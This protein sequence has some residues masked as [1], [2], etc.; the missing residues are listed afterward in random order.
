MKVELQQD[1]EDKAQVRERTESKGVPEFLKKK[2]I[3]FLHMCQVSE[4]VLLPPVWKA[5]ADPPKQHQLI[6]L[7]HAF[8]DT[9]RRLSFGIPIVKTYDPLTM[10][11]NQPQG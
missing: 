10:L 4:H 11:L 8:E 5:L 2:L 1:K 3:Y 6:T 9:A 7:H